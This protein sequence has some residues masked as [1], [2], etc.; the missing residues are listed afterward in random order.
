MQPKIIKMNKRYITRIFGNIDTQDKL[1]RKVNE[2]YDKYPFVKADEHFCHIYLW[3]TSDPEK[4]VFFGFETNSVTES[5]DFITIEIPACEWAIFDLGL[6]KWDAPNSGEVINWIENNE[7]YSCKKYDGSIYQIEYH[8][9]NKQ[10]DNS[11][12]SFM[13]VWYPLDKKCK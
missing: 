13:E 7:K 5:D 1:W 12:E 2:A 3:E 11:S 10:D 4:S 8:K 9:N 6:Q